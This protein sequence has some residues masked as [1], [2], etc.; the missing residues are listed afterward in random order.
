MVLITAVG[1]DEILSSNN[2]IWDQ[3]KRETWDL[4]SWL[5]GVGGDL[6]EDGL[7][8]PWR[9]I[10]G[11]ALACHLAC[12][13]VKP[14]ASLS[15]SFFIYKTRLP[16][17]WLSTGGSLIEQAI[18]TTK[19]CFLMILAP[20]F[21]ERHELRRCGFCSGDCLR[22]FVTW[23]MG[24]VLGR[25]GA[26]HHGHNSV[27]SQVDHPKWRCEKETGRETSVNISSFTTPLSAH[28]A[29]W[30]PV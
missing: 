26:S 12:P 9:T 4:E 2:E 6:E 30:S 29:L 24:R 23:R 22:D 17:I 3:S 27:D 1:P 16:V 28:T 19:S 20:V 25:P 18:R 10:L 7:G 15:L 14:P 13:F 5:D 8:Q 11:T 21:K